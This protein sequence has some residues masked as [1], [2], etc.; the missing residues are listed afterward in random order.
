MKYFKIIF[1]HRG[2]VRYVIF[3]CPPAAV[4]SLFKKYV[5]DNSIQFDSYEIEEYSKSEAE[6]ASLI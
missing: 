6:N 1:Y 5:S 4:G 2:V 3:Y